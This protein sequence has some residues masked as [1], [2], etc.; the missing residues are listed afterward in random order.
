MAR[1]RSILAKGPVGGRSWRSNS[2]VAGISLRLQGPFEGP[3]SHIIA[4]DLVAT[5]QRDGST[6]WFATQSQIPL[7]AA[8][9]PMASSHP[10]SSA[11]ARLKN[12]PGSPGRPPPPHFVLEPLTGS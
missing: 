2:Q 5:K 3:L 4:V 1:I 7:T 8:Q 10:V 9:T 12:K 11:L 6:N